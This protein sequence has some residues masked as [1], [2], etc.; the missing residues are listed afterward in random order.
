VRKAAAAREH[1]ANGMPVLVRARRPLAL[2]PK[3]RKNG[4]P[5]LRSTAKIR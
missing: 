5:M 1:V 3:R 2:S 4:E